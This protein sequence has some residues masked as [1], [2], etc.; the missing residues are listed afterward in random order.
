VDADGK[1]S[2]AVKSGGETTN[3]GQGAQNSVGVRIKRKRQIAV[4]VLPDNGDD[5]S[6]C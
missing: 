4:T 1:L 6:S 5:R 2:V 3:D